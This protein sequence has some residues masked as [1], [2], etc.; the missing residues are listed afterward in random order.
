MRNSQVID[1]MI[2]KLINLFNGMAQF[3]C[4]RL[5]EV[6]VFVIVLQVVLRFGFNNPT[7]WSEEAALI[8]LVWFG[9]LAAA[10]C[11]KRHT[12]VAITFFSDMLPRVIQT[13]LNIF[14]QI[15]ILVF[16]LV[17]I[18]NGYELAELT[19][20]VRL[21]ASQIPKSLLYLSAV[22]GGILM[23]INAI[24]NLIDIIKCRSGL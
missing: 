17:L 8:C 24:S 14:T 19:G 2:S 13:S 4:Y 16:A 22:V 21:P 11:V 10:I 5:L 9:M 18:I 20:P 7:K 1:N 3:V 6:I 12:H 23:L 15:V